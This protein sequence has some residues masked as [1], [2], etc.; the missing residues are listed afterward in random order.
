MPC[1]ACA[2]RRALMKEWL[3]KKL[4]LDDAKQA[5]ELQAHKSARAQASAQGSGQA[6]EASPEHQQ[7]GVEAPAPAGV[8]EGRVSVP[9]VRKARGG[10]GGAR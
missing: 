2:R 5:R 9:R 1:E 10:K 3:A 7:Q 8:G 6:G 4:R